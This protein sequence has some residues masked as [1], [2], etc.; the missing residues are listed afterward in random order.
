MPPVPAQPPGIP[1][2]ALVSQPS[3]QFLLQGS[4]PL[5]GCGPA[6]SLAPVPTMLTTASELAS[7]TTTNN[8]EERTTTPRP[9]G[10]KTKKEEVSVPGLSHFD[11]QGFFFFFFLSGSSGDQ[12]TKLH[13]SPR[14]T[15]LR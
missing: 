14:S 1:P 3:V 7:Q 6:Q 5:V 12:T 2:Y 15:F 4:L 8:S 11:A 10:E 9:A 13:L